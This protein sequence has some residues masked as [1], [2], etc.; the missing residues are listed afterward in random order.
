MQMPGTAPHAVPALASMVP[1]SASAEERGSSGI[2][3]F[4]TE[5]PARTTEFVQSGGVAVES[6]PKIEIVGEACESCSA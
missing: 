4:S 3:I 6:R 1:N 5:K 2:P